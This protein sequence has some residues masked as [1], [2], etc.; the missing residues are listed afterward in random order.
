MVSRYSLGSTCKRAGAH[1]Q[2]KVHIFFDT[3]ARR[4]TFCTCLCKHCVDQYRTSNDIKRVV[5][6]A[7]YQFIFDKDIL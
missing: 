4:E 5:L 6:D 7:A 1:M 3:C 2:A